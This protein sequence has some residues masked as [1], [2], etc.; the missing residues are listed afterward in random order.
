MKS[1]AE[2]FKGRI[3]DQSPRKLARMRAK[4]SNTLPKPP[5]PEN[6]QTNSNTPLALFPHAKVHKRTPH[7]HCPSQTCQIVSPRESRTTPEI[8]VL[9]LYISS[10]NASPKRLP[11]HT[12]SSCKLKEDSLWLSSRTPS[13]PALVAAATN[14]FALSQESVMQF[15]AISHEQR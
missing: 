13:C 5:P 9:H 7:L 12:V 15:P 2:E 6:Y 4:N 10:E 1:S 8:L 14:A 11:A 3:A